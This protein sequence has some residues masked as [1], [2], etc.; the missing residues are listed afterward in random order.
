MQG[1]GSM[2][3]WWQG[4]LTAVGIYFVFALGQVIGY[5]KGYSNNYDD[6]G[7]DDDKY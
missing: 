4:F 3:L 7:D 6:F 5:Y 1:L 2:N